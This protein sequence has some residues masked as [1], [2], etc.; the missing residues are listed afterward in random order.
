[1]EKNTN[2]MQPNSNFR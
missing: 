2:A 1:M